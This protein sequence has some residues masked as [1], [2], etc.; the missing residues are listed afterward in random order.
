MQQL[1]IK[2]GNALAEGKNGEVLDATTTAEPTVVI[3]EDANNG[4]TNLQS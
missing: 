3:T 4:G 2:L 1:Q